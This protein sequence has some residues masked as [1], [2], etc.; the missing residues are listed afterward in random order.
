MFDILTGKLVDIN[1]KT[2][3]IRVKI[4]LWRH[5]VVSKYTLVHQ[6]HG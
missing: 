5:K 1:E 4:L 6:S 3:L 2:F